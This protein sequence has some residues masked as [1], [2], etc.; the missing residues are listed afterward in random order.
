MQMLKLKRIKRK[1]E[2]PNPNMLRTIK[3]LW[4]NEQT[5]RMYENGMHQVYF[6]NEKTDKWYELYNHIDKIYES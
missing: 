3:V 4:L 1:C 2:L 6:H 5:V